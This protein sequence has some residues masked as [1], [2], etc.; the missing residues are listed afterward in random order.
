MIPRLGRGGALALVRHK[1]PDLLMELSCA[2]HALGSPPSFSFRWTLKCVGF[3]MGW[4][5]ARVWGILGL[6]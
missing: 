3:H 5:G 6:P 2:V 1:E 4:L